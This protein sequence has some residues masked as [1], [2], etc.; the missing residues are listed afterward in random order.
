MTTNLPAHLQGRQ[1][2]SLVDRALVGMSSALPPHISI[3][4]N[5]FTLVDAAGGK[6]PGRDA[7][8]RLLHHRLVRYDG[9]AVL[10]ARLRTEFRRSAN[11]FLGQRHRAVAGRAEAPGAHMRRVPAKCSW[12]RRVEIVRQ[13]DQGM[14]RREVA[15]GNFAR[16]PDMLFQLKVT[17]GSFKNWEAYVERCKSQGV[18][19]SV[20]ITRLAFEAR[21]NG[22]LTFAPLNG[23]MPRSPTCATKRGEPKRPMRWS[24]VAARRRLWRRLQVR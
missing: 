17:P 21:Q 18:D 2:R 24:D 5:R 4:G 6:K 9:E 14:S 16:H 11:M 23:S 1:T 7:V 13:A 22:V 19:M 10:R 8:S 12:V 20:L 15:G 3:G